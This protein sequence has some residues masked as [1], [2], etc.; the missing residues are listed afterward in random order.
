GCSRCPPGA[1]PR[2]S[3]LISSSCSLSQF[4]VPPTEIALCCPKIFLRTPFFFPAWF[5]PFDGPIPLLLFL[6]VSFSCYLF[7]LLSLV[8]SMY[9]IYST[10]AMFNVIIIL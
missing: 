1:E 6:V 4:F 5:L 10:S 2:G 9:F 7:L 3:V 8:V